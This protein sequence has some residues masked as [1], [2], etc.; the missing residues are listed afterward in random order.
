MA[1]RRD[2]CYEYLEAASTEDD[3][4]SKSLSLAEKITE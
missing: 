1:E 4:L 3:K 2:F